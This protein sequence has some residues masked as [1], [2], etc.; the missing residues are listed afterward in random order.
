MER[1]QNQVINQI[2]DVVTSLPVS[3]SFTLFIMIT[4]KSMI[5]KEPGNKKIMLELHCGTEKRTGQRYRRI[6]TSLPSFLS[7]SLPRGN[8]HLERGKT[9]RKVFL[10]CCHGDDGAHGRTL[11][12]ASQGWADPNF[13][14]PSLG[15]RDDWTTD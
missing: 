13:L 10:T 15:P 4:E 6:I 14:L 8:A 5:T 12:E 1:S 3:F 9:V 11:D 7:S 2:G